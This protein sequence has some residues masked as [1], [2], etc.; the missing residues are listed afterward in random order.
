[1]NWRDNDAFGTCNVRALEIV[2][3]NLKALIQ[4]EKDKRG[5]LR[6]FK[7]IEDATTEIGH[8]VGRSTVDRMSKGTTDFEIGNLEAIA[9]VFEVEVWQLL[10]P[11]FDPSNPPVL[12]S[13]GAEEDEIY[14][15]IRGKIGEIA[16]DLAA[17]DRKDK[18]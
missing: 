15:K 9:R 2:A 12:R 18:P 13:V 1:M 16:T 11:N 10:A 4:R 7:A 6:T 8:T 3:V 14:R 17:I 5:R